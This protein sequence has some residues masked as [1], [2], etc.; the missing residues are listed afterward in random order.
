MLTKRLVDAATPRQTEYQLFD[1]EIP[2]LALRVHPNA[3]K[4]YALF[5]RNSTGRKRT[6][7]LGRHGAI[8]P[9]QA[10]RLAKERLAEVTRG[11]DPAGERQRVRHAPDLAAL[12]ERY[13]AEHLAF[14]KPSTRTR[15]EGLLKRIVLPAIGKMKAEAVTRT[16]IL[17]LHRA[18]RE[19]PVEANRAVTLLSGIF[20][21]AEDEGL[22]LPEGN[23]CRRIKKH[24]E[25]RRE[26]YLSA[27]ELARLGGALAQAER[28]ASEPAAAI[29]AIR[30]LLLTGCRK[31][32]ILGLRWEDVDL[33]RSCLRLPDS[34]TGAKTVLL[35]AAALQLL[36]KAAQ[37][38][39]WV[40]PGGRAGEPLKNL[41]KPWGRICK[42]AG[43]AGV[44]PHD[45]RHGYVS[46]GAVGGES[47]VV[48]GAI[49]GHS[50]AGMTERYAH[51]SDDP[52]RAAAD[53]ISSA[54]AAAMSGVDPAP[55]R[56]HP[57]TGGHA[58]PHDRRRR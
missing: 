48:I 19:T 49:V 17:A 50:A 20:T 44:R 39:P 16:D 25:R 15:A 18:H 41:Y 28:D 12:V 45:L 8:T 38:G 9:E 10:R 42:A 27:Q 46:I 56:M 37:Q 14:K 35:G 2:G 11:A 54:I 55:V 1:G 6:L 31:S 40:C 23:P 29:L 30:L 52:V 51:L 33:E 13:R 5:Y 26:R 43:L 32:E 3:S 22:V 24:T 47:L 7:T 53:R 4:V 34:K 36:A 57:R 58:G 21:W